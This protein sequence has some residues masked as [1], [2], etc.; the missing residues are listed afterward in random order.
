MLLPHPLRARATW[1][2]IGVEDDFRDVEHPPAP[3]EIQGRC[4]QLTGS[5][6]KPPLRRPAA[7]QPGLGPLL[8]G[9]KPIQK[10]RIK[11]FCGH[12]RDKVVQILNY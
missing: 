5:G 6:G 8:R 4:F 11:A 3:A 1:Q 10:V 12:N 7:V 9:R 2:E